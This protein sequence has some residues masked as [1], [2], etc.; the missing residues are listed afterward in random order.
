MIDEPN[1]RPKNQWWLGLRTINNA[2]ARSAPGVETMPGVE[3]VTD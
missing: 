2:L 3:T 1:R